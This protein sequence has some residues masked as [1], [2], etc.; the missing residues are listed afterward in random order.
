MYK[1]LRFLTTML[2]L[3]VCCGTWAEE[4]TYSIKTTSSVETLGVAPEG[5][6]ATFNTTYS[7]A[8]QLTSGTSQTLT[9]SGYSGVTITKIT[10]EM[11][12][13][14][15]KGAGKLSYSV[16]GGINYTYIIGTSSSGVKFND[17]AW[18]GSW[19]T[20]WVD[21]EKEVN[22]TPTA[23][24]FIIKIE[25]TENSLYC[26][27]YTLTYSTGGSQTETCATPSFTPAGGTYTS[28]QSVTLTCATDGASIYYRTDGAEPEDHATDDTQL[29]SSPINVD[30]T[31]T[32]KAI[33]VKEGMDNS[34]VATAI[35]TIE[36][37]TPSTG[38]TWELTDL[39]DLT[40]TDVF[41]IVGNNGDNYAMTNDN[42]T[43]SAPTAV[44]V[45]VSND[46]IAGNVA[47]NL[48][49]NISGNATDGY[50]FYPNGSTTTWLYC[51]A[52]NNGVRVGTND[53]KTF[54]INAGYL[55]HDGTSRY[56]GIYDSQDWRCYTS[57]GG[58]IANQ[59]F[60]FYK[61]VAD[62]RQEATISFLNENSE[63]ITTLTANI[64]DMIEVSTSCNV[65]NAQLTFESDN[66]DVASYEDG[67]VYATGVGTAV[68]TASFAGNETY[69]P[70]TATLTV[71]VNENRAESGLA[72]SANSINVGILSEEGDY[73][74]PTLTNPNN[75]TVSYSSSNEGVAVVDATGEILLDTSAVGEA[76]ITATFAGNN[77]Y[78]PAEVSYT[79]N[80]VDNREVPTFAWS[81]STVEIDLGATEYTLPT[82]TKPEGATVTYSS[83]DD[84]VALVDEATGDV[85]VATSAVATATI[86]ATFAGNKSYKPA[87]ASYTIN[88][89]DPNAPGTA[90]RPYSVADIIAGVTNTSDVYVKG[91]I[92]GSWK[93]SAFKPD[94]LVNTN[95][96]LAD[97]PNEMDG[98]KTIP[99]EL[100]DTF[101]PDF[102]LT[103]GGKAYNVGVAQVL[104]NGDAL[105]YFNVNGVKNLNSIVKVAEQVSISDAG[106]S[107]YYTD[108]ALD[109]T[110]NKNI[111]AYTVTDGTNKVTYNKVD[112]VPAKTAVVLRSVNERDASEL[113]PV[114]EST[115]KANS[116]LTGTLTDIYV[117][118]GYVLNNGKNGVGFYKANP[119]AND[120][121]GTKIAAHR[122]YLPATSGAKD[123]I[124]IDFESVATAISAIET[125]TETNNVYDLQGRKVTNPAKG[126]Y[127]VNGKKVVIK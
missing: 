62:E 21:V 84:E 7:T 75:V 51:T 4:V 25:A 39:A 60:A 102:G 105:T 115:A 48:K 103:D 9:L 101:R 122:A 42:G 18:H 125:E 8:S 79:I 24:N 49:W 43:G 64:N 98:D 14:T 69:K 40:S 73:E 124:G 97:D 53:N 28:A 96:A 113:I 65:E 50:T 31:M 116:A 3:A 108:C 114:I 57:T 120:G 81:E 127:I 6:S 15:S 29:Y 17:N 112:V 70:A 30:H 23:S 90:E 55:K 46:K 19:S 5:S 110:G 44:A 106:M 89:I 12:S 67:V 32:I 54:K 74:L 71:T 38:G 100:K 117:T 78:K 45:V 119:Q 126:L 88:I 37:P 86:T 94:D 26:S 77:D 47:D 95:L 123:F 10:L 52:T 20:N 11:K 80:I 82:L 61:Y 22:I 121:K 68:I 104:I 111:Y 2:L 1:Q 59:R 33:A 36:E 41:V 109:F 13:N 87:T 83:S 118:T 35:Y 27:K 92:V 72:W 34:A 63:A 99:V 58:N 76:T 107:T 91:F 16:D 56:V 66:E 85:V 93:N